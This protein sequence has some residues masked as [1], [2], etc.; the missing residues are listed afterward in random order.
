VGD[1]AMTE[2]PI[3]IHLMLIEPSR[4]SCSLQ[5]ISGNERVTNNK[6]SER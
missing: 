4:L 2:L 1:I 5:M 3:I 6:E